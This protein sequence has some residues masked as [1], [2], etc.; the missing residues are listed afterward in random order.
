MGAI[1]FLNDY[2][3]L[4]QQDSSIAKDFRF[5]EELEKRLQ[6]WNESWT[7]TNTEE[8]RALWIT[9]DADFNQLSRLLK[10]QFSNAAVFPDLTSQFSNSVLECI[11][12]FEPDRALA[13]AE[14]AIQTYPKSESAAAGKAVA[15]LATK[16]TDSAAIQQSLKASSVDTINDLAESL[17]TYGNPD[18]ALDLINAAVQA[19]PS[20]SPLYDSLGELYKAR[21]EPQKAIDAFRKGMELDPKNA[22]LKEK[23]DKLQKVSPQSH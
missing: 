3:K 7:R 16:S 1:P 5:S 14:L 22:D 6:T 9:A 17:Y 10:N 11:L 15:L 18:L 4:Y 23:L 13:A 19:Y 2:Q 8:V 20:S 21:N 12:S